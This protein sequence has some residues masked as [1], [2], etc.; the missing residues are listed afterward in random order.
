MLLLSF[1]GKDGHF[2]CGEL[3]ALFAEIP[4]ENACDFSVGFIK[5]GKD[6]GR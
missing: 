1:G 6:K 3:L 5:G 2:V 4:L